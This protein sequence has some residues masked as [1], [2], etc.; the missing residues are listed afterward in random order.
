MTVTPGNGYWA[1]IGGGTLEGLV[2]GA[3]TDVAKLAKSIERAHCLVEVSAGTTLTQT[4]GGGT[5]IAPLGSTLDETVAGMYTRVT[6]GSGHAIR[7]TEDGLYDCSIVC[8]GVNS[9]DAGVINVRGVG[10]STTTRWASERLWS[11]GANNPS[12]GLRM[13]LLAGDQFE[14]YCSTTAGTTNVTIHQMVVQR[15]T[16]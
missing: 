3:D 4:S 15:V 6:S 12:P 5:N 14:V 16:I 11:F 13:R 9:S 7:V 1:P 10:P 8:T 2:I